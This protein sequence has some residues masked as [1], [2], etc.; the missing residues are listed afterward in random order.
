MKFLNKLLKVNQMKYLMMLIVILSF[1]LPLQSQRVENYNPLDTITNKNRDLIRSIIV[2]DINGKEIKFNYYYNSNGYIKSITYD[3]LGSGKWYLQSE[4][5]YLYDSLQR[6]TEINTS[7]FV[8]KKWSNY[9]KTIIYNN[10][11][12]SIATSYDWKDSI[13]QPY[14][15]ITSTFDSLYR[16]ISYYNEYYQKQWW[17]SYREFYIYDKFGNKLNKRFDRW[18]TY[19]DYYTSYFWKYEFDSRGYVTHFYYDYFKDSIFLN[20][21]ER[22]FYYYDSLNN[23]SSKI[24]DKWR[25]S[26]WVTYARIYYKY[27]SLN[28]KIFELIDSGEN[29]NIWQSTTEFKDF[30]NYTTTLYK[31]SND[32]LWKM[33]WSYLEIIDLLKRIKTY[34]YRKV[35]IKGN[36]WWRENKLYM[37]KDIKNRDYYFNCFKLTFSYNDPISDVEYLDNSKSEFE[38]SP[39]P[40]ADIINIKYSILNSGN[41][42]IKI[43]DLFGNKVLDIENYQLKEQ[44]EYSISKDISN[45]PSGMYFINLKSSSSNITKPLIIKR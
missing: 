21:V 32:S 20:N 2:E 9:H 34:E 16:I 18:S 44:G 42:S 37:F 29:S 27:D 12:S 39:N 6:N 23:I 36:N 8:N 7:Q 11:D 13:W 38:I 28:R 40:S 17:S 14:V 24:Y 22:A 33:K 4:I 5:T 26:I 3:T 10:L 1:N 19:S 43:V 15:R 31:N 41:I 35:N 30:D 25:D 45:I